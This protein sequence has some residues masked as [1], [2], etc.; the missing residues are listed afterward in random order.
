MFSRKEVN[1]ILDEIKKRMNIH[2]ER[3]EELRIK[4]ETETDEKLKKDY[5]AEIREVGIRIMEDIDLQATI[6]LKFHL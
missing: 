6:M 3:A 4:F 5:W 2:F 1:E